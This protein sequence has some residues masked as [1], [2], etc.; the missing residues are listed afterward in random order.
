MAVKFPNQ[1][2]CLIIY[3]LIL[4][5]YSYCKITSI[6]IHRLLRTPGFFTAWSAADTDVS[7]TRDTRPNTLVV[8]TYF[9]HFPL[10]QCPR[11]SLGSS[12]KFGA[13]CDQII[14]H[15]WKRNSSIMS[16]LLLPAVHD[17]QSIT[18]QYSISQ[19]MKITASWRFFSLSNVVF[20][21]PVS[22][23]LL[24]FANDI[25]CHSNSFAAVC[26]IKFS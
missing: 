10:C 6:F 18:F 16:R 9:S 13:L 1:K 20:V 26:I 15:F 23:C 21:M 7:G 4:I 22:P 25:L 19:N 17:I 8:F 3:L 11:T 12:S 5:T 14:W 2:P 24:N